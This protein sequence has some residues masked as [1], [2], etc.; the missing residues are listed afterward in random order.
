MLR[1]NQKQASPTGLPIR[2][3]M[4]AGGLST[5]A[6]ALK[7]EFFNTYNECSPDN[8]NMATTPEKYGDC[9]NKRVM[10]FMFPKWGQCKDRTDQCSIDVQDAGN[11]I[12]AAW[13]CN[14][15]DWWD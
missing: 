11:A 7:A 15:T 13:G 1:N 9:N 2:T 6:Q 10:N 14:W 12:L 4:R 3:N 8:M 5:A